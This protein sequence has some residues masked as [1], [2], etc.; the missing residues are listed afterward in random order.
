MQNS[1]LSGVLGEIRE[2]VVWLLAYFFA[3]ETRFYVGVWEDPGDG[4]VGRLG[5]VLPARKFEMAYKDTDMF[6]RFCF[7][8]YVAV[9]LVG[10]F[11]YL[12]LIIT[13]VADGSM[14]SLLSLVRNFRE[15]FEGQ[16][17]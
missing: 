15:K 6:F 2:K 17:R 16:R 8:V 5:S 13:A 3:D 9:C 4:D 11:V 7:F 10:F 12:F 14:P 1:S